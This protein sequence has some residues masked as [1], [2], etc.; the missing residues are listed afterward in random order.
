MRV[1]P[2]RLP[3]VLLIEPRVFDDQ[4]GYFKETFNAS[5]YEPAGVPPVFA[6]DNVSRSVRGTLRG[7]HLQHPYDQAKL[8][9]VV[10]GEVLDVAV[11]VRVGS[12]TFGEWVA[13]TLSADNHR[14]LF[15]PTGFAHGFC[16]ISDAAVFVYKC[17]S[18]Y[19][20]ESE[21]GIAFD[22]PAI[23][24]DWPLVD[25]LVRARDRAHPKLSDVDPARLPTYRPPP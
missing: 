21:I 23:G 14:Q 15:I 18:P 3:D 6:Q 9:T 7:L 4:R 19:H 8:V 12:P 17:T 16:V 25:P 2:Q 1:T 20:Q 10:H 24:I 5:R 11:D 22:D 13:A